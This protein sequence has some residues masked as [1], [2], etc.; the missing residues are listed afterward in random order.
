MSKF[1]CEL[2]RILGVQLKFTTAFHLQGNGQAERMIQKVVQILCAM[3][4]LDQHDWAAKLSMAEF[5]IN[6]S[7]NTLT[8]FAPFELIYGHMPKMCLTA[9]P[10]DYPGVNDF[11]QKARDN[12][13]AAHDAIIHNR[14]AQTIQANKKRCLD[15]P[16][17]KGEL[18]YLSIDKLNLPKGRAGKLMPLYIGPYE[19]LEAI[20]ETLNY[21]LKLPLQLDQHGIHPRSH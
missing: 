11:A 3:V 8:G 4:R 13:M 19:V 17:K 2:R 21:I 12:L 18:A 1:W 14:T 7:S 5:M 15:L 16:L 6:V 10:S 9:P 20:P